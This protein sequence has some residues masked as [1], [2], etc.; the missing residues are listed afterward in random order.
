MGTTLR[1]DCGLRLWGGALAVPCSLFAGAVLP[2][3]LWVC[4]CFM[5]S[6]KASFLGIS[7]SGSGRPWRGLGPHMPFPTLSPRACMAACDHLTS[8]PRA[9]AG[10]T[11]SASMSPAR[12]PLQGR[13]CGVFSGRRIL[14]EWWIISS[15][16]SFSHQ[17]SWGLPGLLACGAQGFLLKKARPC[18]RVMS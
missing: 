14:M 13:L 9:A 12:Q 15:H 3:S 1:W 11:A 8:C 7:I 18:H 17:S 5:P 6:G 10:M 16:L 2:V 4:F